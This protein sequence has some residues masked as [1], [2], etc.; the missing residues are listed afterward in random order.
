MKKL[1]LAIVLGLTLGLPASSYAG[2]NAMGVKLPVDT[3][4]PKGNVESG[5]VPETSAGSYQSQNLD[6][7][8]TISETERY[9]FSAF[10]VDLGSM[11]QI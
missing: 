7:K 2:V 3:S 10:G 8:T 4:E 6:E 5:F 1:L 11:V 9:T